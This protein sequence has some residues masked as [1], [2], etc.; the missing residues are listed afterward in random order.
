MGLLLI[1]PLLV[2]GFVVCHHHPLYYYKLH[3]QEGQYF[4]IQCARLG[5]YSLVIGLTISALLSKFLATST[6]FGYQLSSINILQHSADYF[7]SL[8]TSYSPQ[9]SFL[10]AIIISASLLSIYPVP[11]AW[12]FVSRHIY[13]RRKFGFTSKDNVKLA[14]MASIFKDSPLDDFLF[15]SAVKRDFVMLHMDDRKVYV[16]V[17]AS[18]GEPNETQGADQE[19]SLKPVMSGFRD[20]DSLKVKFT[21]QYKDAGADVTLILRQDSITSATKFDFEIFEKFAAKEQEESNKKKELHLVQDTAA[22]GDTPK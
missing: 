8:D 11:H 14:V 2:S 13:Y 19:V 9:E 6:I 16:G 1:I 7:S 17:I 18:M 10:L 12:G 21:T 3:R 20:K 15:K 4:Y 22:A 5:L